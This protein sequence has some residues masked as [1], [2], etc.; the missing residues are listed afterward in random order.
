MALNTTIDI[1]TEFNANGTYTKDLS[2]WDFC[3]V[4]LVTP[5]AAVTFT[6][7]NDS[8]AIVGVSDGNPTAAVNFTAVQGINLAS[9]A[10][11]TTLA[12]SGLVKFNQV[13]RYLRLTSA[14]DAAKVI[15]EMSKIF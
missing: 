4:Q 11:V 14:S 10:A 8:G 9:G 7:S 3:V 13:G 15:L 2:N 5:G 1:T 12:A 6:A